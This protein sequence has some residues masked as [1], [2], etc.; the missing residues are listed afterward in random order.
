[1]ITNISDKLEIKRLIKL[2]KSH[3]ND[4][5]PVIS[6]SDINLYIFYGAVF[7]FKMDGGVPV[8]VNMT[9][10]GKRK[11]NVW[12]PYAN[13]YGAYTLPDCRRAG[14]ATELYRATEELAL[15]AGCRR[16]KSLAG[17]SAGLALHHSLGHQCWGKTENDEVWVDSPLPG[18]EHLYSHNMTPPQTPSMFRMTTSDIIQNIQS[19]L[20]YDKD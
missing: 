15:A 7:L 18:H 14:L 8:S 4:N 2:M 19:G 6:G 16:I 5:H 3:S 1:M 10:I 13:W 12:E 11:K 9:K 20:R 17:S